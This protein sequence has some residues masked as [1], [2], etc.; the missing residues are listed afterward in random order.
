VQ[1][2]TYVIC[3]SIAARG[4]GEEILSDLLMRSRLVGS[5]FVADYETAQ[6][7]GVAF[8]FDSSKR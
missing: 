8:E 4:A 2:A 7:Q 1:A 5:P 6:A 3:E